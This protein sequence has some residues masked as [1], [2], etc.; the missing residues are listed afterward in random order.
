MNYKKF[1]MPAAI[2]LG[3]I[4]ISVVLIYQFNKSGESQSAQTATDTQKKQAT[5]SGNTEDNLLP[6]T[7]KDHILGNPNAPIKI[8]EFSDTECPFCKGFHPVLRQIVAEYE[9]E[10]AWVYRHFPLISIHP[11]ALKEAEAT[12]CAA[13]LGGN[14]AFWAYL[15]RIF[16]ITPSN[17]GLDP[18]LL[19]ITAVNIGLNKEAFQSCMDSGRHLE[20]IA[21]SYN[22]AIESGGSGTPFT[23]V[24]TPS[25][26]KIP[27]SGTIELSSMRS[28]IEDIKAGLR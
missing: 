3:G 18:N 2:V 16:E 11:R 8:V 28:L 14:T 27:F 6:I 13:E 5:T 22:N 10:V 9:G 23:I 4:L 24:I 20:T 7:E 19:P 17:N 12:E 25:G 21:N 1:A 26:K 15:D